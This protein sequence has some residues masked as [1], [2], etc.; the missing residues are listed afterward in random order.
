MQKL[1]INE[2]VE[3]LVLNQSEDIELIIEAEQELKLSIEVKENVQCSLILM[4]VRASSVNVQLHCGQYSQVNLFA[5]NENKEKLQL[6]NHSTVEEEA[7]LILSFAEFNEAETSIRSV[8][9]L[10]GTGAACQ[11]NS[12]LLS[13]TDKQMTMTIHHHKSNTKS[14]M[15]HSGVLLEGG[16]LY[17]DATGKIDKGAKGSKSHQKSRALTFDQPKSATVLPQ[18]LI[19]ENDVEASHATSVGQIDENQM[20]YLQSRG[21]T[22]AEA[23]QLITLGALM[24]IA[25]VLNDAELKTQMK[26]K[27][28]A[29]VNEVCSM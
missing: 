20:Y 12:A 8:V 21:L 22:R 5:M 1:I 15:N 10:S 7:S 26:S 4:V 23:T 29:K 28:E 2:L 24:P 16:K 17:I 18:L 13:K 19:D 3:N 25:E 9:E 14:H 11:M 6:I 27:I